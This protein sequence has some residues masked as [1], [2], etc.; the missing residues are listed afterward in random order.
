MKTCARFPSFPSIA[1]GLLLAGL[2]AAAGRADILYVANY[3]NNTIEKFTPGGSGSVF[4]DFG[5]GLRGP[6][7][8]AFDSS[9]NLYVSNVGI[10]TIEKFTPGGVGS[11]FASSGLGFPEGLAFDSAGNLYVANALYNTIG[12]FTPGGVGSVFSTGTNQPGGLAFDSA[13]NLYATNESFKTV[14]KFNSAGVGSVFASTG[15]DYPE[16]IAFTDNAGKPLPL[17]NQTGAV[18]EPS[19]WLMGFALSC[20]ALL[21]RRR[22]KTQA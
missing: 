13:G 3:G 10:G 21:T 6:I 19:T 7:G 17:A 9:G 14:T 16:Y 4:A 12:K 22:S 1:A 20:M 11:V 8:L 5:D 18:P 2:G 15:L